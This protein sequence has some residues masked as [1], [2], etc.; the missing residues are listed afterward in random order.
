MCKHA[1]IH[2]TRVLRTIRPVA[3]KIQAKLVIQ[4]NCIKEGKINSF[5]FLPIDQWFSTGVHWDTLL[6]CSRYNICVPILFNLK[7]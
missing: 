7:G 1:F 3:N 2:G 6:L 4:S 5:I